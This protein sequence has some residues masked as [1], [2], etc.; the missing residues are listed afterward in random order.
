MSSLVV[1]LAATSI[2]IS[3]GTANKAVMLR[4]YHGNDF[5]NYYLDPPYWSYRPKRFGH[6]GSSHWLYKNHRDVFI[7]IQVN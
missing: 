4:V 1:G 3:E 5:A 7:D 6:P 2:G